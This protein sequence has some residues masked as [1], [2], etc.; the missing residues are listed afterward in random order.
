MY[1]LLLVPPPPA[2]PPRQTCTIREDF[3]GVVTVSGLEEVAVTSA[4]QMLRL[5]QAPP[6]FLLPSG[7]MEFDENGTCLCSN[8]EVEVGGRVKK[9]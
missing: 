4:E 8:L 7:R 9:M 2:A 1:V 5:L 6:L 3:A